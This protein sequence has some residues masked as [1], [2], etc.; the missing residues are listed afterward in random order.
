MHRVVYI[1]IVPQVRY[2]DI[3]ILPLKKSS[4]IVNGLGVSVHEQ[5]LRPLFLIY[6][7]VFFAVLTLSVVSRTG[8]LRYGDV[9]L[10][11]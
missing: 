6:L 11:G 10:C 5:R 9:Q 7:W 8:Y 3:F 2:V 1:R 4:N